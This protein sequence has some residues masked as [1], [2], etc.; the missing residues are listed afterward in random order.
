MFATLHALLGS[1]LYKLTGSDDVVVGTPSSDAAIPVSPPIVGLFT[2]SVIIRTRHTRSESFVDV[3]DNVAQWLAPTL[4]NT[5]VPFEHLVD[6]L[7]PKRTPGRNPL[8]QTMLV[9]DRYRERYKDLRVGE[10]RVRWR[11]RHRF[12]LLSKFDWTFEFAQLGDDRIELI[13]E[14]AGRTVRPSDCRDGWRSIDDVRQYRR[15][16]ARPAT[17]AIPLDEEQRDVMLPALATADCDRGPPFHRERSAISS[18][19]GL[20]SSLGNRALTFAGD[21]HLRRA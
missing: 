19:K 16:R 5:D 17:A 8:F 10:A 4:D 11:H 13:I 9:F 12:G 15:Q 6:S 21:A 14:Y 1:F 20:A 18:A 2:N 3:I 7:Q